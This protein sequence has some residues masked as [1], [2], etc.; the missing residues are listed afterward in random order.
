VLEHGREGAA[1]FVLVPGLGIGFVRLE[2][3]QR[4]I[5][6]LPDAEQRDVDDKMCL[7]IDEIRSAHGACYPDCT[8]W[9]SPQGS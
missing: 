9:D 1:Q 6:D 8:H 7:R 3:T 4:S 5:L 2:R